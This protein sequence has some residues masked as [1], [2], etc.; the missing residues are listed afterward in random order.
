[1]PTIA[2]LLDLLTKPFNYLVNGQLVRIPL[3]NPLH[4]QIGNGDFDVG[5]LVGDDAARRPPNVTGPQTAN[6]LDRHPESPESVHVKL[7]GIQHLSKIVPGTF[8]GQTKLR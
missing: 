5:T 1:M 4:T 2:Q 3:G 6:V 8:I 7:N